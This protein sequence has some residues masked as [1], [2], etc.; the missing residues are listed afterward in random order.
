M[1]LV[2]GEECFCNIANL[3][4][5]ACEHPLIFVFLLIGIYSV[6]KC[7]LAFFHFLYKHF[8]RS[9]KNLLH[10]GSHA[11][12]TGATDGI[13]LAYA[14]QLASSGFKLILIARNRDKLEKTRKELV[15]NFKAK[16]V[17]ILA[18]D[19]GNIREDDYRSIQTVVDQ[20]EIGVLVN[21]V[22][23]SYDYPQ[24]Y[25]DLKP[26][27]IKN[28]LRVNIEAT[29]LITKIILPGMVLRKKGCILNVSSSSSLWPHPLLSLYAGSKSFV[30]LFSESLAAE[31]GRYGI[32]VE[33]QT[34]YLVVSNLSKVRGSSTFVPH[35]RDFV[36]AA[37]SKT[38]HEH[39]T[40][41]YFF[42]DLF[43]RIATLLPRNILI[44][45]TIA[46]NANTQKR[47]LDKKAKEE[48]KDS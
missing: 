21:N 38:G 44:S 10:Y 12:I 13:G 22:G 48:K 43:V 27:F 3:K 28:L 24:L 45:K 26:E 39:I 16:S 40:N 4:E 19:L 2:G 31:Y 25:H 7:S 17:E 15:E 47:A 30:N 8:I 1:K 23:V 46:T 32:H 29:A 6:V 14:K 35:P 33:S 18:I 20:T 34:P 37:L 5:F 42:H 11:L 9:K 36:S 41:P